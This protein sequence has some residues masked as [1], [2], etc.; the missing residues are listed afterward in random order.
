MVCKDTTL[1]YCDVWNPVTV[2]VNTSQKG[3]GAT[4]LQD[5]CPVAFASKA[6]TPVEQHYANIVHELLGYV[7]GA[8]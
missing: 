7:F 4:L 8:E 5:G 6:L 3:L 1:Y 2:Q